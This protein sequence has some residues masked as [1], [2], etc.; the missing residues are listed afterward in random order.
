MRNGFVYLNLYPNLNEVNVLSLPLVSWLP[1]S[2]IYKN[3]AITAA[4]KR[5]GHLKDKIIRLQLVVAG[6][7]FS[8][9]LYTAILMVVR[10]SIF[11]GAT[12]IF[13]P[14]LRKQLAHSG[15]DLE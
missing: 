3:K 4:I 2:G 5:T 11:V 15:R 1:L 6:V 7:F 8:L 9:T 14:V 12:C 10:S 13:R